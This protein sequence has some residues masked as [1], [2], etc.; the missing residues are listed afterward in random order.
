MDGVIL[1][2]LL[3]G[4]GEVVGFGWRVLDPSFGGLI[5]WRLVS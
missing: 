3:R 5:A 1:D 2:S 4:R